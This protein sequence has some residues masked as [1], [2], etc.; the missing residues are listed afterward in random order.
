MSASGTHLAVGSLGWMFGLVLPGQ[1]CALLQL[2]SD[3]LLVVDGNPR[4][5][6]Q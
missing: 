5:P 4:E 3:D 1:S 6:G 2:L